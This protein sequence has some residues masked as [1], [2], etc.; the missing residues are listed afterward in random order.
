VHERD[1]AFDGMASA[2]VDDDGETVHLVGMWVAPDLRG[3]GV[4]RELVGRI[5]EWSRGHGRVRVVLSVEAG[6]ERAA[7]LYEKSGFVELDTPPPLGYEAHPGTRFY[8]YTL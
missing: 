4:A 3:S 2:F 5:I 1:D 8:A 6:N 7:R